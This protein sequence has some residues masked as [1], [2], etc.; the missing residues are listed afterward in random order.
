MSLLVYMQDA[1]PLP[2]DLAA[3]QQ[4]IV[5]LA[6]RLRALEARTG[7]VGATQSVE[8]LQFGEAATSGATEVSPQAA[9]AL[10]LS[11]VDDLTAQLRDRD[12][13]LEELA[14]VVLDLQHARQGLEQEVQTLQLTLDKLLK[15]IYGRRGERFLGDPTQQKFDF[16]DDPQTEDTFRD[17]VAEAEKVVQ[18][19]ETR[20]QAKKAASQPQGR[21]EKFPEH[22]S[23]V[24]QIID[25]AADQKTCVTHGARIV[26]GYDTTETLKIKR[27]E[28][29][30]EVT[31]YPKYAC[32]GKSDCG[33]LQA[34]R[35]PGLVSG[36]R[37]DTSIG[38]EVITQK[39]GYHLPYYRQQDWFAACGWT[40]SRSTLLNILTAAEAVLHPLA[41]YYRQILLT[42]KVTGCDETTI[43]LIVPPVIPAITLVDPRSK[44]IHEVFSAAKA[45]DQPSVKA[46]MWAYRGIDIPLNVFDFTVSRHRDGPD[47]IL[48]NYSGTLMAD[49]WSGFQK[50]ELRSDERITRAACWAHA[51]RKVFDGRSSHPLLAAH[52][53]ALIQQLYDVE[54]RGKVLSVAERLALR[55]RESIALL[56]RIRTVMDSVECQLVLPKSIFAKALGYLRNHWTA[57][58]VYTT[59]GLLPIDNNDVEQL[60]KQVAI[61]RKNWLFLGSVEAGNRTATLLTL[62]SSAVRH[63]LDVGAYL[64]EVLDQLLAGSMDYES[65]RADV[66][67][68]SHPEHVRAYRQDERQEASDRRTKKRAL[69]RLS[70][71]EKTQGSNQPPQ[72]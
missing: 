2:N 45:K 68:Q 30:V 44:R 15:Q 26:I 32:P 25:V 4:M 49:C 41:D 43:T 8:H 36:N 19:I 37:F 3:C 71:P 23:R 56:N 6:A 17:A 39:H 42:G 7:V 33:V 61:G 47:E 5:E 57:L 50:I 10:S 55:Q 62:I 38:A 63:D 22:L 65:M 27:P 54:D 58:L 60:M 12:A 64:K 40:P 9:G 1:L 14:R 72:P 20:R 29:Y 13:R 21:S 16:G 11:H 67:K 59:N 70:Q 34:P 24:E 28:L 35:Q 46:R 18:E 53:L 66:W 52:L 31:K 48:A 69:R 51:R